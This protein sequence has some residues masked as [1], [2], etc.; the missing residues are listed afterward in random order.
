MERYSGMDLI[1]AY[2]NLDTEAI[3][4][5]AIQMNGG[6]Q[7]SMPQKTDAKRSVKRSVKRKKQPDL[8]SEAFKL[9]EKLVIEVKAVA[10]DN[11]YDFETCDLSRPV[12]TPNYRRLLVNGITAAS[13]Y[14]NKSGSMR[15]TLAAR[16]GTRDMNSTYVESEADIAEAARRVVANAMDRGFAKMKNGSKY[17]PLV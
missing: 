4:K 9:M 6:E 3:M 11:G 12:S 10:F 15:V 17:Q 2:M 13:L 7:A 14:G 16:S 5:I 8:M 1:A